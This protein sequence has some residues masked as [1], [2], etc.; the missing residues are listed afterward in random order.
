MKVTSNVFL[1]SLEQLYHQTT[2][3]HKNTNIYNKI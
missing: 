1:F 2:I 3:N